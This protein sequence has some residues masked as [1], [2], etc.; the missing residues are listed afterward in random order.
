M[1]TQ[2]FRGAAYAFKVFMR[3]AQADIDRGERV[4]ARK[5]W[6]LA[7][8]AKVRIGWMKRRLLRGEFKAR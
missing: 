6:K 1:S 8:P 5:V 7:N 3:D 2:D 4:G